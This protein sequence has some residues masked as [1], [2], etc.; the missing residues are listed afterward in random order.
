MLDIAASIVTY[1]SDL[2]QLR[3]AVSSFN[4]QGPAHHLMIVDNASSQSYRTG[5]QALDG[6]TLIESPHN[7]GYGLWS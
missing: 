6:V 3:E 5:L 4:A 1:H 7:G 2:K